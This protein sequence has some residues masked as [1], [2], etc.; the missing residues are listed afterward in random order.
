MKRQIE[1]KKQERFLS[2]PSLDSLDTENQTL[3]YIASTEAVDSHDSIV[4]QNWR[5]DRWL[6]NPIILRDHNSKMPIGLGELTVDS[7]QKQTRVKVKFVTED[8]AAGLEAW[9]LAKRGLLRGCSVSFWPGSY[10]FEMRDGL[11]V[12]VFD[13]NELI[14]ISL[15]T[16]PSNAE[17]LARSWKMEEKEQEKTAAQAKGGSDS[18]KHD[19][20]IKSLEQR[21]V[22][23]ESRA[24]EL[25]NKN[26]E[27]QKRLDESSDKLREY[28]AKRIE[29]KVRALVGVKLT[30]DEIDVNIRLCKS[31]EELFDEQM[32]K[33]PNLPLMI[34]EKVIAEKAATPAEEGRGSLSADQDLAVSRMDELTTKY[35]RELGLTKLEASKKAME[36]LKKQGLY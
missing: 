7:V 11:D 35:T 26:L 6:A 21:A 16:L 17:C 28:E 10:T 2:L 3:E 14:E 1:L 12:V 29:A 8:N 4:R 23:A 36:D 9:S 15:T 20:V 30:E 13:D 22:A 33:R 24:K 27:L 31:S 25:E 19:L 32:S 5:L 34:G 18:E